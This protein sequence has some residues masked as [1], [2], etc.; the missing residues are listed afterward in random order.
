MAGFLGHGLGPCS[1]SSSMHTPHFLS[2]RNGEGFGFS[3]KRKKMLQRD[4]RV[5]VSACENAPLTS[6]CTENEEKREGNLTRR[7]VVGLIALAAPSLFA[8]VARGAWIGSIAAFPGLKGVRSAQPVDDMPAA[9]AAYGGLPTP[10]EVTRTQD[11]GLSEAV[12]QDIRDEA[13]GQLS[14]Q[15][16]PGNF[17]E[18]IN[19]LGVVGSGILGALYWLEGRAK[20][21]SNSALKDANSRLKQTEEAMESLKEKLEASLLAQK[22]ES[23]K[24]LSKSQQERATILEELN[25]TKA[26]AKELQQQLDVRKALIKSLEDK[27]EGFQT[28]IIEG[29]QAYALLEKKYKEEKSKLENLCSELSLAREHVLNQEKNIEDLKLSLEK[30]KSLTE[31]LTHTGNVTHEALIQSKTRIQELEGE[32]ASAGQILAE[33]G[34]EV[35]NLEVRLV[36]AI[37]ECDE[38]EKKLEANRAEFD[39]ALQSAN[40]RVDI[41]TVSLSSKE[42]EAQSLAAKLASKTLE[43]EKASEAAS[44]LANQVQKLKHSFVQEQTAVQRLTQELEGASLGLEAASR[45]VNTLSQKLADS[46]KYA[47]GLE[48]KISENQSATDSKIMSLTEL[49]TKEQATVAQLKNHLDDA[50]SSLGES[51]QHISSLNEELKET[52]STNQKLTLELKQTKEAATSTLNALSEEKQKT[53]TAEKKVLDFQKAL[54]QEEELVVRLRTE[55]D[56][57]MEAMESLRTHLDSLSRDLEV[58]NSKTILLEGEKRAVQESLQREKKAA[59]R[60][61][62][63]AA[64]VETVIEKVIQERENSAIRAQKLEGELTI[65][66][67]EIINLSEQIQVMGQAIESAESRI[68]GI[69]RVGAEATSLVEKFEILASNLEEKEALQSQN[70]Q[71]QKQSNIVTEIARELKSM[72]TEFSHLKQSL[73]GIELA[74]AEAEAAIKSFSTSSKEYA[75]KDTKILVGQVAGKVDA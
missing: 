13:I 14:A 66:K 68:D 45:E 30:Q 73:E 74:K 54:L 2:P 25:S 33:K 46:Q 47:L 20:S 21:A 36:E 61:K 7:G 12:S 32:I 60:F 67:A 6:K 51:L 8:S 5:V 10:V 43:F 15:E 1:C 26:V 38:V 59:K 56:K 23:M 39:Q 29:E 44:D 31:E 28:V 40:Q 35:Q 9:S 58:A 55:L 19:N 37:K 69:A 63:R 3:S 27:E 22:E 34:K 65:A 41:L 24:N 50:K 49:L 17:L 57:G 70:K 75:S 16:Q 64:Q 4:K 18:F 53:A 72:K 62:D 71:L 52:I 48:R 42:K 11:V